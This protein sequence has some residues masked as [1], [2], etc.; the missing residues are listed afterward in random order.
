MRR[1]KPQIRPAWTLEAAYQEVAGESFHIGEIRKAITALGGPQS[2]GEIEASATL[3]PEPKNPHDRN[4]VAVTLAGFTVGY[5]PREDASRYAPVLGALA[6]QGWLL[7]TAARLWWSDYGDSLNAS[8]NLQLAPPNMLVPVNSPP[9]V[10][11]LELPQGHALQVVGEDQHMDVLVPIVSGQHQVAAYVTLHPIVEQKTRTTRELIEVRLNGLRVGQ[12]TPTMSEHLLPAVR[13]AAVL[14]VVLVS[15]AKVQ[16]NSLKAD[17]TLYPTRAGDL[18][19]SWL[20]QLEQLGRNLDGAQKA[21]L[22]PAA[23]AGDASTPDPHHEVP[24]EAAA[25]GALTEPPPASPAPPPNP[26]AAW[27][28]NPTGPGLRWWDGTRWTE[29]TDD[30]GP[31]ELSG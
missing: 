19:D 15:R 31:P 26:P 25:E 4:A 3:V 30:H 2:S 1:E 11:M 20:E 23:H 16:G 17:V 12:L 21:P 27:V 7:S 8:V 5:L 9:D 14:G 6:E 18:P 24:V 28:P 10:P 13:R 29:Y 22:D